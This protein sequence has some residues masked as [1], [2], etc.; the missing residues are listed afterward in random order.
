M[1]EMCYTY[2]RYD[3]R[4]WPLPR[5]LTT[6]PQIDQIFRRF[7]PR[8]VQYLPLLG[9]SFFFLL[10]GTSYTNS[11]AFSKKFLVVF[12][13]IT[14]DPY[15]LNQHGV[16]GTAV[17]VITIVS[18]LLYRSRSLALRLNRVFAVFKVLLIAIGCIIAF[19]YS[20]EGI[21]WSHPANGWRIVTGFL[22]V[23]H[24]YRGWE[25]PFYVRVVLSEKEQ[26]SDS[27]LTKMT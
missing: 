15:E 8:R 20:V 4:W 9:Y 24:T 7:L 10:V 14:K 1:E 12:S 13:P 5:M 27:S 3:V 25:I 11:Y 23:L 18:F 19:T 22:A 17:F 21:S 16:K 26:R 6:E 2:A